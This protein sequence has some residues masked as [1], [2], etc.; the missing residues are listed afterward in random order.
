VS[1]QILSRAPHVAC[2]RHL[3]ESPELGRRGKKNDGNARAQRESL[4]EIVDQ[5][6]SVSLST[7]DLTNQERGQ[8][9]DI[10]L[11]A[12]DLLQD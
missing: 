5:A 8:L 12:S 6:T 9:L 4:L 2:Y 3:E 1:S 11:W 7:C 10:I